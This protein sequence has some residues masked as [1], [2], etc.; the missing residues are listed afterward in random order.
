[1]KKAQDFFCSLNKKWFSLCWLVDTSLSGIPCK[2]SY[3]CSYQSPVNKSKPVCCNVV[4]T[5]VVRLSLSVRLITLA[6]ALLHKMKFNL[7]FNSN[8]REFSKLEVE[9]I[10]LT[11]DVISES[12]MLYHNDVMTYLLYCNKS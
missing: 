10:G 11:I 2:K 6:T 1:M 5:K 9:F 3:N 12:L 8:E 7:S 4:D